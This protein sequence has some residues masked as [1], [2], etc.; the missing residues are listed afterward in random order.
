MAP[1]R[2]SGGGWCVSWKGVAAAVAALTAIPAFADQVQEVRDAMRAALI[3][4]APRPGE[5]ASLPGG[6]APVVRGTQMASADAD[7]ERAARERASKDATAAR[8]DVANRGAMRMLG[9]SQARA[10]QYGCDDP[11]PADMMKSRGKMAGGGTMS[12]GT[13]GG[14]SGGG[15]GG[16]PGHGD[17]GGG[18]N[19]V[20]GPSPT[21]M[22]TP[23]PGATRR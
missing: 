21:S 19:T 16:M 5:P 18:G 13:G 14:G 11:L 10:G 6:A 22:G 12:G 9:G 4:H 20:V 7:A 2:D 15:G 1:E 23:T 17:P 3:E 8:A